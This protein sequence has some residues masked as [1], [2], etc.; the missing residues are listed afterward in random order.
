MVSNDAD[1]SGWTIVYYADNALSQVR[2]DKFLAA[3]DASPEELAAF[4]SGT[5]TFNAGDKTLATPNRIIS[6]IT[7]DRAI[8]IITPNRA[9]PWIG[10]ESY[11]VIGSNAC[12]SINT[13]TSAWA[14]ELAAF[15]EWP[16]GSAAFYNVLNQNGNIVAVVK[17]RENGHFYASAS[18]SAYVIQ[19]GVRLQFR[20]WSPERD[21]IPVVPTTQRLMM[22]AATKDAVD[23][24][25]K[26]FTA[27]LSATSLRAKQ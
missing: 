22:N 13:Q 9:D 5:L 7:T 26:Q 1:K 20:Q 6:P 25:V 2:L 19:G 18:A 11:V 27:K 16:A 8:P 21:P 15:K 4:G 14:Q 12:A 24:A 17:L 23:A 10:Q 3:E